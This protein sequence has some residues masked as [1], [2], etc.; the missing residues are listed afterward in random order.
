MPIQCYHTLF[1]L[2]PTGYL[3]RTAPQHAHDQADEDAARLESLLDAMMD[4]DA[5]EDVDL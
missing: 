3:S 1:H 5:D 4:A 2:S